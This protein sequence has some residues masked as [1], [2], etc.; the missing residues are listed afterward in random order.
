MMRNSTARPGRII[1]IHGLGLLLIS[2]NLSSNPAKSLVQSPSDA[3]SV[4]ARGA[5]RKLRARGQKAAEWDHDPG[6]I[7][8][9][10]RGGPR[11]RCPART[12][13]LVLVG[14]ELGVFLDENLA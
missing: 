2:Y 9:T 6:L 1:S 8:F 10:S 7:C 12:Q 5:I 3:K 14:N 4:E 11:R 13:L